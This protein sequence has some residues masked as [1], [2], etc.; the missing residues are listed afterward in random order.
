MNRCKCKKLEGNL[1]VPMSWPADT[2]G[3]RKTT[4]SNT[5]LRLLESQV[6]SL[7]LKDEPGPSTSAK[8]RVKRAI[9]RKK[10]SQSDAAA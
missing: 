4:L 10:K 8:G 5:D 9:R 1:E 3:G 7:S 6:A 2:S